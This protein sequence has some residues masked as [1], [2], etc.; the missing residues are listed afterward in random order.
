MAT[1][2]DPSQT[3]GEPWLVSA[4]AAIAP[5][6]ARGLLFA[7][8]ALILLPLAY[9]LATAPGAESQRA[10]DFFQF[11]PGLPPRRYLHGLTDQVARDSEVAR[12]AR[13]GY[14][15]FLTTAFDEGSHRVLIGRDH[16][17]F[18]REDV[19]LS[20]GTGVFN[21]SD[22][23]T[24]RRGFADEP[25]S[26]PQ[27]IAFDRHV[28]GHGF[29]LVVVPVPVGPVLYPEKIWPAYPVAAGPAWNADYVFWRD[30]LVQAGVDLVDVTD[31][32]WRAKGAG[33]EPWLANN[34][35]W[36]PRG[37]EIAAARIADRVRP[38]LGLITPIKLERRVTTYAIKSDL[39][40]MLDVPD[41]R[42]F[43]PI[44][45][46][47]HDILD[48][49]GKPATGRPDAPVLLLGDSYSYVYNGQ[50]ADDAKAADLGRQLMWRLKVPV[51]AVALKAID[52]T[53]SRAA[54]GFLIP[55]L[56]AKKVIV[57]E[58]TTRF[59]QDKNKWQTVPFP[60]LPW[61]PE[62]ARR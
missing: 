9:Q 10:R 13:Q 18:L 39:A 33:P 2:G 20:A 26:L 21:D 52:P 27:I 6:T 17:L 12:A 23:P 1:T 36:S 47:V 30:R 4:D 7:F 46:E 11:L 61:M 22:E 42:C 54:L 48:A 51:Q 59:L 50:D 24:E 43:A 41:G 37:V 53:Q 38:H 19:L 56:R 8:L 5:G 60:P 28:R 62:T 31:D 49:D 3:T 55:S 16:Y 45:S 35:H 32:L 29:H 40:P 15:Q 34:T 44:P 57:W 14:Q 58:F 25:V